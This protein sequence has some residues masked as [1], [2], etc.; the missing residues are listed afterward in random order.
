LSREL[1]TSPGNILQKL[2]ETALTLERIRRGERVEH[3][4]TVR[5]RKDGSRIDI[6]LTFRR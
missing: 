5:Q 1:A 3:H 6:S 2:A 4:E